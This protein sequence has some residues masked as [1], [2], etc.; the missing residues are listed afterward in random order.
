MKLKCKTIQ[1]LISDYIDDLL[2]AD[3]AANVD[4]HL[5]FCRK[6]QC[7]FAALK[8]TRDLVVDYYVEP[9]TSD[10]YFHQFE[11]ELNRSIEQKGPTPLTERLKTSLSQLLWCFL[12]QLRQSFSRYSETRMHAICISVISLLIVTSLVATHLLNQ[13]VSTPSGEYPNR[14]PGSQVSIGDTETVDDSLILLHERRTNRKDPAEVSSPARKAYVEKVGYWKL[15]EALTTEAEEHLIVMHI[16]NDP[17]VPSDA[18]SDMIVYEQPEIINRKSPLQSDDDV[19]LPLELHVTPLSEKYPRKQRKLSGFVVKLMHVPKEILN[20]PE[21][22]G[23][24]KL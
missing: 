5:Q 3:D 8:K 11:V 6:C 13:D 16:S 21:F 17:S 19:T 18:D 23:L 4:A 15:S 1:R 2:S 10:N 24:I 22:Y 7:E 14:T 20:I 9:V 12:T